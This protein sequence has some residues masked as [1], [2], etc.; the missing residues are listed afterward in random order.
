[1]IT[2]NELTCSICMN[3]FIDPVTIDCGHSFCRPCLYL[4]WEED[5]T[6]KSCPECRGLSEKPDFKTNIVLKRLAS[7]ARQD[8]A[9]QTNSLEGQI[10]LTHKEAKGL[11]CEV[12]KTLLCGPCS[13]SPEHAAHSHSPIQWAAEEYREKLLKRMGSLWKM[14]QEMQNHLNLE[15][16]KT[17]S[18][19]V[20]MKMKVMIKDQYQRIHLFLQEQEQLHLEVLEEEAKEILQ[21]L[22]ESEFRMTQQKESLKEMYRELTEMCHKPDLELLQNLG[23]VLERTDLVQMQKPQPVNPE[24]TSWPVTGILDVLNSFRVY[25]TLERLYMALLVLI[26]SILQFLSEDDTTMIY[27]DDHHG[28]SRELQGAE[29][30][31]AWGAV[32]FTSGRHYWEVDVTHSSNWIL[33]VCKD[34]LTSNTVISIDSEEAFLL[35][36][37]KVNNHY[38]LSTNSPPLIQYVQRPL[39]GIGVFLDYDNGTVSFYDVCRGSLIYTFLPSFFS[40]PLKPFLC[41]RS[42]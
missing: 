34:I 19:E 42:P 25:F 22:R 24:L 10:C 6:P 11:F 30:F 3:Y 40:S 21:Q 38:I 39:G 2:L 16:H 14:T 41:L 23:N 7:L 37:M 17:L 8:A 31:V 13:E 5:Q 32:A 1:M 4:C 15:T 27:G 36:S 18:L 20:R 12:D 29:S 9:K 33:G 35:S 28:V 26:C